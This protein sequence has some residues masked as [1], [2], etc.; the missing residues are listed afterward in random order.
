MQKM[1]GYAELYIIIDFSAEQQQ[2]QKSK[3]SMVTKENKTKKLCSLYRIKLK[4]KTKKF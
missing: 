1:K 4:N 2:Q 3:W